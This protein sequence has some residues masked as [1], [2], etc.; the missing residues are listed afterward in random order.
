MTKEAGT[1]AYADLPCL[2]FHFPLSLLTVALSLRFNPLAGWDGPGGRVLLGGRATR[3]WG[4]TRTEGTLAR[5]CYGRC[6]VDLP[7]L[8]TRRSRTRSPPRGFVDEPG[9]SLPRG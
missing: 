9:S 2:P 4:G 8:S 7:K 5:S 6:R 3:N 1:L